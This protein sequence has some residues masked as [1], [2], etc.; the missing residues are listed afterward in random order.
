M[1]IKLVLEF[2][3]LMAAIFLGSRSGGVGLG[4]W[5][6][7]RVGA[8]SDPM[9]PHRRPVRRWSTPPRGAAPG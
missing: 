1:T 9:S 3:V 4:L 2:A 8:W 6:G 7:P 5:G